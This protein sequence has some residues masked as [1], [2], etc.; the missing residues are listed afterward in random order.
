MALPIDEQ[1]IRQYI[2][3]MGGLSQGQYKIE[4]GMTIPEEE[5]LREEIYQKVLLFSNVQMVELFQSIKR[6]G[7]EELSNL[8]GQI[9]ALL[10][11]DIL[12]RDLVHFRHTKKHQ[13]AYPTVK[14]DPQELIEYTPEQ[15][16]AIIDLILSFKPDLAES[17][18]YD[19]IGFI[20]DLTDKS[21][22]EAEKI[23]MA[24]EPVSKKPI[25]VRTE[26]V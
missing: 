20:C 11:F 3:I 22:H 6:L 18:Y 13:R 12:N 17:H 25:L 5:A 26:K 19:L 7:Y 4:T 1:F 24:A 2:R 21:I 8:P 16:Q 10:T 9:K 23:V 15:E 14:Y